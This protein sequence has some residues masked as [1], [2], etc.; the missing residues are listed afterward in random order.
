MKSA[1]RAQTAEKVRSFFLAVLFLSIPFSIAGDDFAII[2]LYLVT[3]YLFLTGNEQW[4]PSVIQTGMAVFLLGAFLAALF[5]S[6][7]LNGLSYARNFWRIGLPFLVFF[8]LRN[9]RLEFYLRLLLIV[10][11]IIGLYAIIQ[12]FTGLDIL[13]TGKLV[14]EYQDKVRTNRNF[15]VAA[16]SHHLTYGGVSLLL[17][18][19]FLPMVLDRKL[20]FQQRIYFGLGA[21]F[22]L[23]GAILCMGRSI[24]LALLVSTAIILALRMRVKTLLLVFSSALLIAGTLV[25]INANTDNSLLKTK[26]GKRVASYTIEANIARI[27]MWRAGLEIIADNPVFGL[28]PRSGDDMQRYYDR[29]EARENYTFKHRAETGVHN[30]Y[31]Q[32]WINF[33]ILGLFGYLFWWFSLLK[34]CVIAFRAQP[35]AGRG[36]ESL[37]SGLIGGFSGILFAGIF[38]NNFRDG[39]VQTTILTL[40]GIALHL[41]YLKA[42]S[43]PNP[44]ATG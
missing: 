29:F 11:C 5:S 1:N 22:N 14:V 26:L 34:G 44:S 40:M 33:G 18:S 4:Q 37:L 41:I 23:A 3:F 35:P 8:A 17:Y 31:I 9:R 2:G 39:E 13:R 38:E 16:F 15:A 21:F 10:S 25:V 24:W 20:V 27:M 7:I 28:G 6:D 12:Y 36:L 30:I 42:K 32:N 43:R 19:L